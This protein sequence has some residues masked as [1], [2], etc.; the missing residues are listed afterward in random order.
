[1]I[2]RSVQKGLT[3]AFRVIQELS[4]ESIQVIPLT[5]P[6]ADFPL[7]V[8]VLSQLEAATMPS[9]SGD[10]LMTMSRMAALFL[11]NTVSTKPIGQLVGQ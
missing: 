7:I 9:F 6:I 10:S 1:L 3:C 2:E 11:N 4:F 8:R 5:S